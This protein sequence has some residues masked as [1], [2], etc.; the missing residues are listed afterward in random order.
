MTGIDYSRRSIDYAAAD[1]LAHDWPITYRY[2]NY[3]GLAHD[4]AFDAICLIWCDMLAVCRPPSSGA[5][6]DSR[7]DAALPQGWLA[8]WV[9]YKCSPLQR[10]LLHAER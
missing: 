3:L 5:I 9:Q 8:Y 10:T 4:A 6:P 2:E 7:A 1:A